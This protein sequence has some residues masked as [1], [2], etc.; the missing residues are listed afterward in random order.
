MISQIS[1][2]FFNLHVEWPL[3]I[4][5]TPPIIHSY[6]RI[7]K[8][9]L[10]LKASK[11][12]LDRNDI[13][14][15]ALYKTMP[16]V[17]DDDVIRKYLAL[18]YKIY[19]FIST[20]N[21]Y[22]CLQIDTTKWQELILDIQSN[23]IGLDEICAKHEAFIQQMLQ[24]LFLPIHQSETNI[25]SSHIIR[26]LLCGDD[27]QKC[28]N[29]EICA[30]LKIKKELNNVKQSSWFQHEKNKL[31]RLREEALK[32]VSL[33]DVKFDR[34]YKFCLVTIDKIKNKCLSHCAMNVVLHLDF[35]NFYSNSF[36]I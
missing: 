1:K 20:F 18:R 17:Y 11:L 13:E 33:I 26:L 28:W 30:Y 27:L 8:F 14:T 6:N 32:S 21:N 23:C 29:N 9:L 36:Q 25:I 5:I 35:N 10:Q 31:W 7:F 4:V 15:R 3:N 34:L 24:S 19:L 12:M 16:D 22:C 2:L